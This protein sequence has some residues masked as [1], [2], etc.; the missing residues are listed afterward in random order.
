MYMYIYIYRFEELKLMLDHFLNANLS[1][2]FD[3]EIR[4]RLDG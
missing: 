1:R 2:V 4:F 3:R